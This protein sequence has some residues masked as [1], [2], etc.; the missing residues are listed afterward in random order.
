MEQLYV[1]NGRKFEKVDK[2]RMLDCLSEGH[3]LVSVKHNNTSVRKC[4]EPDYAKVLAAM[5]EASDAMC[6]V[7]LKESEMRPPSTLMSEKEQRAWAESWVVFRKIIGKDMPRTFTMSSIHDII[8]AGLDELKKHI[9]E[10]Y[11]GIHNG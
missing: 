6:K 7:A 10:D 5:H 11:N 1:R 3:W 4:I 2:N 8:E 9:K